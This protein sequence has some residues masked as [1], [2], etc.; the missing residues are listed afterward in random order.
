MAIDADKWNR[1]TVQIPVGAISVSLR[2]L[3]LFGKTVELVSS[4]S[5]WLNNDSLGF[6]SFGGQPVQMENLRFKAWRCR[7]EIEELI[8]KW[9][10]KVIVGKKKQRNGDRRMHL[11]EEQKSSH[12]WALTHGNDI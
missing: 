11:P 9:L 2:V 7:S 8:M 10:Y 4:F 6:S 3:I 1:Q 12:Y 5:Y